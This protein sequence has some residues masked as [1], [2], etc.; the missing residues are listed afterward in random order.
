MG[1]LSPVASGSTNSCRK[2]RQNI[3][4]AVRAAIRIGDTGADLDAQRG[5]GLFRIRPIAR[6]TKPLAFVVPAVPRRP[7]SSLPRINAIHGITS[8]SQDPTFGRALSL[9]VRSGR[10]SAQINFQQL[11]DFG[12]RHRFAEQ[13]PL[14]FDASGFLQTGELFGVFYTF[15]KG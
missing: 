13:R 14:P 9:S 8:H 7:I 1:L 10:C 4:G 6:I 11:K 2:R 3:C 12:C 15:R 5:Q